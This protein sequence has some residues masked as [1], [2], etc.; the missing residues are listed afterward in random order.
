MN[1]AYSADEK[2]T[3][4]GFVARLRSVIAIPFFI[5]VLVIAST[6]AITLFILSA[7][8]LKNELIR[9]VGRFMGM[10]MLMMLGVRLNIH[11]GDHDIHQ[12]AVYIVNHSSTLDLF[13]IISLGLPRIRYVA[14]YELQFNPF[15]FMMGRLTGQ[16][17][18]NRGNS[19]ASV[20]EL[21]KAYN[22]VR[23][24]GLSVLVAPEGSR[25]HEMPVGTF[26]KGAFRIAQDLQLPVVPVFIEGAAELCPGDALLS[27]SGTV[28]V[29]FGKPVSFVDSDE[30]EFNRK[31]N[32]L[33]NTY[34]SWSN[35]GYTETRIEA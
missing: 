7:G 9:H 2:D 3:P 1:S 35:K 26:K 21:Q 15:F 22:R 5:I 29:W 32:D 14:K 10:S 25:K 31:I 4:F 16:I 28:N 24:Q 13:I 6:V 18:I 20:S 34:I 12:Q 23:K 8:A 27:R 33:R 17:F 11:Y 30:E 19:A